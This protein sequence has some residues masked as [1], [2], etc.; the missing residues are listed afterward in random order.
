[1]PRVEFGQFKSDKFEMKFN[2]ELWIP[3][4]LQVKIRWQFKKNLATW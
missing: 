3:E 4:G 1:M 2:Y